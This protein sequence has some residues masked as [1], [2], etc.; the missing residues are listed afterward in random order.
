[1]FKPVIVVVAYNRYKSLLRLLT[2]VK[3]SDYP[4]D[5]KLIISI[6]QGKNEDVQELAKSF[7]WPY[8]EK[9]IICHKENLGVK[10]HIFFCGDLT[11]KYGSIIL[12][13]DDLLVSPMFFIYA[14][15]AL[16]YYGDHQRIAGIS[17]YRISKNPWLN[18]PFIPI[19]DDSD[20][21]FLQMP[22]SWGQVWTKN[23]WKAF[24]DWIK[25][26][27]LRI[28]ELA[29]PQQILSWK[30]TAWSKI[31][32]EYMIRT[33]K[34][35]VYPRESLTTNFG[36]AGAHFKRKNTNWQVPL[37]RFKKIYQFKDLSSS[38][39]VYDVY[40]EL[41]PSRFTQFTD[42]F[43]SYDFTVDL[44]GLKQITDIK[45]EYVLTSKK[46]TNFI[47]G[48]GMELKPL[49]A[50]IFSQF[51]GNDLVF[52]HKNDILNTSSHL[53][54]VS[55]FSYFYGTLRMRDLIKLLM[56]KLFRG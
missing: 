37:Q 33:D 41:L 16:N 44:Y 19:T 52:C 12:L 3:N 42:I 2:S 53:S 29:L 39:S 14:E 22:E 13:E 56:V 55:N 9:E 45:T 49:E 1:M 38:I 11:D 10:N 36:I 40:F 26:N 47:F 27:E 51:E 54:F 24:R 6:D 46:N 4:N 28:N 25:N 21:F 48:F 43:E 5:V 8:G 17:L 7:D 31:F 15:K 23:Q 35:F 18:L 34:Y 30:D 50:N 32:I 20:V